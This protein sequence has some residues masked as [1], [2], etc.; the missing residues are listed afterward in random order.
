MWSAIGCLVF[1]LIKYNFIENPVPTD[2][3]MILMAYGLGSIAAYVLI[4]GFDW[5]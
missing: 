2:L 4:F 5:S 1:Y 3:D